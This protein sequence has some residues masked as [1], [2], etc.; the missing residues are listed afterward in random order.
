MYVTNFNIAKPLCQDRGDGHLGHFLEKS[1]YEDDI[2][3][4]IQVP[5]LQVFKVKAYA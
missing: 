1:L 5:P 3:L 2:H 4:E